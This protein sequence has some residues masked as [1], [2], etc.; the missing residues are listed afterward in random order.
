M[1]TRPLEPH[2]IRAAGRIA[3]LF[4]GQGY[5]YIRLADNREIYF[6]RAE[7]RDG[8]SFNDL[9]VGEPVLFELYEDR[10]SGARA[11]KVRPH[12]PAR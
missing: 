5:G 11:L 3:K 7:V 9:R 2:G 10:V 8:T 6:H 4:I 12:A 1:L